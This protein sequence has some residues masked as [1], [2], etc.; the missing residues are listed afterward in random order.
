MDKINEIAEN[1]RVIDQSNAVLITSHLPDTPEAKNLQVFTFRLISSEI[2]F[3]GFYTLTILCL[4]I[5]SVLSSDDSSHFDGFLHGFISAYTAIL[6]RGVIVGWGMHGAWNGSSEPLICYW[7]ASNLSGALSIIEILPLGRA[8]MQH[9]AFMLP[10][11]VVSVQGVIQLAGAW[12]AKSL[13]EM[14]QG[15]KTKN[16]PF[17]LSASTHLRS[18]KTAGWTLSFALWWQAECALLIILQLFSSH[19]RLPDTT[20]VSL[21]FGLHGC[22]ILLL[23]HYRSQ[24]RASYSKMANRM[25]FYL[26]FY[27]MFFV[28]SAAEFISALFQGTVNIL[29]FDVPVLVFAVVSAG[30]LTL[31]LGAMAGFF[32]LLQINKA[33]EQEELRA[34]R[35]TEITDTAIPLN[36]LQG[37]ETTILEEAEKEENEAEKKEEEGEEHNVKEAQVHD[38]NQEN[39][40]Y[41]IEKMKKERPPEDEELRLP[42]DVDLETPETGAKALSITLFIFCGLL[43]SQETFDYT[44]IFGRLPFQNLF[45]DI[46]PDYIFKLPPV[47][48]ISGFHSPAYGIL[49]HFCF[50][51]TGFS[52]VPRCF[53]VSIINFPLT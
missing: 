15:R 25:R 3:Y 52:Q 18:A 5:I 23:S 33:K 31:S 41:Q 20:A 7:L 36:T 30:R 43:V 50:I 2:V 19:N 9:P 46:N 11:L 49:F 24:E 21:N 47:S 6:H 42:K 12:N 16:A 22:A 39:I 35:T 37:S 27:F 53:P 32:S 44:G 29:Y 40:K 28:I 14:L 38:I 8:A 48:Q 51:L 45:S 1:N 26:T 34:N 4:R 10:L 13:S 17:D